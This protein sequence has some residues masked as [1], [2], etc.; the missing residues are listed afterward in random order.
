M[1][2]K[3]TMGTIIDDIENSFVKFDLHGLYPDESISIIREIILPALL[4]LNKII[5]ITG[6]G[7]HCKSGRS[8]VKEEVKRFLNSHGLKYDEVLGNEGAM[9][10]YK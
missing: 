9:Y 2:L 1:L 5:L 8:V 3:G 10:V 6:R 7:A 4:V